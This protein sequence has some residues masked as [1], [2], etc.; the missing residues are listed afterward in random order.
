MLEKIRKDKILFLDIETVPQPDQWE[1]LSDKMQSLWEK[2]SKGL[3]ADEESPEDVYQKAGIYAEFGKVICVSVGAFAQKG[4]QYIF[5]MKSY[6]SKDEKQ[7]LLEVAAMLRKYS[8]EGE[9]NLCA[10]NGKDFDF[11]YMARRMLINGIKLPGILDTAGKKPWEVN[12]LDTMELWK[13]GAYRHYA[14]LDLLTTIFGIPTPKDD[15]DG[16]QVAQVFYEENDLERIVQYCEKDVLAI[17]QLYLK[18]RGEPLLNDD[19]LVIIK[20]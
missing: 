16:S 7:L 20:E 5:R 17:A 2:K 4:D 9:R 19:Q 15:I 10:H 6:A 1:N 14:S 3:R 8:G 12:H 18:W 13:F 11:P